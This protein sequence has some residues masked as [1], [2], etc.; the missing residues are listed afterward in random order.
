MG[1]P[2]Y[3]TNR[4]HYPQN[5]L[6]RAREMLLNFWDVK[7]L[8]KFRGTPVPKAEKYRRFFYTLQLSAQLLI[9]AENW[10]YCV[11]CVSEI[12][13]FKHTIVENDAKTSKKYTN[14][15]RSFVIAGRGPAYSGP[16]RWDLYVGPMRQPRERRGIGRCVRCMCE[17]CMGGGRV[18]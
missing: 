11:R 14:V 6:P 2:K 5:S 17:L 10:A 13:A 8:Y 9:S 16:Q 7:L 1:F 4:G 15:V 3:L 12:L 18:K